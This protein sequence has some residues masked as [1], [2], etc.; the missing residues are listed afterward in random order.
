MDKLI[1]HITTKAAWQQALAQGQYRAPSLV[2]EGFIHCS[3]PHQIPGVLQRYFKGQKDLV[4][5]TIQS[6]LLEAEAKEE[7][8][9]SINDYFPHVFGPIN[10]NAVVY[11]EAV[12]SIDYKKINAAIQIVPMNPRA[13]AFPIID[14]VIE[15]IKESE[16]AYSVNAFNTSVDGTY[17]QVSRLIDQINIF[18]NTKADEWLCNIQL[19]M[20]AHVDV[21]GSDKTDKS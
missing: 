3:K 11:Y 2:D 15:L 13:E 17:S 19:H 12:Q 16:L 10:T 9:P 7:L 8:A 18:M 20:H 5:L 21:F 14:Q 1:Y 4:Q 6:D